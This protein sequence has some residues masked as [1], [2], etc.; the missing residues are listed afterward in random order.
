M[1]SYKNICGSKDFTETGK[2]KTVESISCNP[3]TGSGEFVK[4]DATWVEKSC[5]KCGNKGWNTG[6]CI[7][8]AKEVK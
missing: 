3:L 7:K 1:R 5:N 2:T 8:Q 6:L 4:Y